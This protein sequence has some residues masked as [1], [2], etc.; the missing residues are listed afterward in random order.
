MS[1]NRVERGLKIFPIS[2]IA[3]DEDT[4]KHIHHTEKERLAGGALLKLQDDTRESR[5]TEKIKERKENEETKQCPN[6]ICKFRFPKTGR[7]CPQCGVF[8]E[9]FLPDN[10]P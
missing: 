3:G 9:K 5:I 1:E 6:P 2:V 10:P 7:K 8:Y 4:C